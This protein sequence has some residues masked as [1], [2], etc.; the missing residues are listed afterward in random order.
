MRALRTPCTGPRDGHELQFIRIQQHV[1]CCSGRADAGVRAPSALVAGDDHCA[2]TP[3]VGLVVVVVLFALTLGRTPYYLV[4]L[5]ASLHEVMVSMAF[6]VVLCGPWIGLLH[7]R[8]RLS[9]VSV[10]VGATLIGGIMLMLRAA[11]PPEDGYLEILLMDLGWGLI[12]CFPV[13]GFFGLLS[14]I[15]FS[16]VA[17]IPL[18]SRARAKGT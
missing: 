10:C 14:G 8:R 3:W 1:T 7:W 6:A 12:F 15:G 5:A 9:W 4:R 17:G 2:I 16:A 13:G 11:W 18:R